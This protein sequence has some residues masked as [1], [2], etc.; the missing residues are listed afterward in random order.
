MSLQLKRS[1]DDSPT[2]VIEEFVHALLVS[3]PKAQ[4]PPQLQYAEEMV[5]LAQPTKVPDRSRLRFYFA[6]TRKSQRDQGGA[7]AFTLGGT[8]RVMFPYPFFK[9]TMDMQ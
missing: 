8:I 5:T 1:P 6:E 3:E 4:I 9:L 2:K 7:Q